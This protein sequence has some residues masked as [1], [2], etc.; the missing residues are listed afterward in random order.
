VFSET[1]PPSPESSQEDTVV[2]KFVQDM[3]F[4]IVPIWNGFY[5]YP[6]NVTAGLFLSIVEDEALEEDEGDSVPIYPLLVH[7]KTHDTNVNLKR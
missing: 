1:L 3:R 2:D 4:N 5:I 7:I 6:D